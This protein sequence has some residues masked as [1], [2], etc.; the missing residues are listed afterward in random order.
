MWPKNG[1]SICRYR[2]LKV[3]TSNR[4]LYVNR[5]PNTL[6]W[7]NCIGP[8]ILIW[9]EYFVLLSLLESLVNCSF[10]HK[11]LL[12]NI[13]S[14]VH[15]QSLYRYIHSC[16]CS[17]WTCFMCHHTW[18]TSLNQFLF[19]SYVRSSASAEIWFNWAC[20]CIHSRSH[21]SQSLGNAT[22]IGIHSWR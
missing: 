1:D 11:S 14:V 19:R 21:S 12:K 15:D 6:L 17:C 18:G 2:P 9:G 7:S 10:V 13:K 22:L 4:G 20:I 8:N 5:T 16:S 3:C